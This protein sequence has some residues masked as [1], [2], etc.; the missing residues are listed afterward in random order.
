MRPITRLLT[1]VVPS[2]MAQ[3]AGAAEMALHREFA[4]DAEGAVDLHAFEV[5][6]IAASVA[7]TFAISTSMVAML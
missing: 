7:N 5:M 2:G 6:R 1:C 4:A 3:H